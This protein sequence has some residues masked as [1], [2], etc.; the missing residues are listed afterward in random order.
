MSCLVFLAVLGLD[1]ERSTSLTAYPQSGNSAAEAKEHYENAVAAIS[2][3]NWQDAKNELLRAGN[4]KPQNA[5]V[6]FDLALAY[7]HTS[8]VIPAQTELNTALR[9][10]LPAKSEQRPK[11]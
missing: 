7:S 6:Q 10:V 9:I 5:L 3:S 1:F 4:L 8:Q 2:K 11:N